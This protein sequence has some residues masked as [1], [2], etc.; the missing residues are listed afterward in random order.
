MNS[1][2]EVIYRRRRNALF[3][4]RLQLDIMNMMFDTCEDIIANT[5]AAGNY[6]NFQLSV[7]GTLGISTSITEKEF[8]DLK[9][10]QLTQKLYNEANEYYIKK[11]KALVE[12]TMPIFKDIHTNRGG[13]VETVAIPFSDGR[14][15][16]NVVGSLKQ[17]LNTKGIELRNSL[18]KFSS[19]TFIDTSWKEHLREMDDLK[20]SVNNAVYEQKDPLLVYKFEGFELFKKFIAKVNEDTVS[21]IFKANLPVNDADDVHEAKQTKQKQNYKEKKDE[22]TSALGTSQIS[23]NRPPA[24]R[25]M[26]VKS[27]K[28]A[29]RN[30]RVS[31]Q[32]SDGS[33]KKDVKFKTVEEDLQNNKC[34]LIE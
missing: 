11:H 18:E 2:R 21:F 27:E 13:A 22:A 3:G 24:E 33:V 17:L 8:T 26:P 4:E 25:V 30:D 9:I 7:I 19:L 10:E 12:T 14:R 23:Q 5:Q 29:N 32:Y 28:V 34:V 16:V 1:Q 20:Q 31:V 15:H 6:D